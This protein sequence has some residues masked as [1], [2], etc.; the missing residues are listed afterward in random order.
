[1]S[2]FDTAKGQNSIEQML[3]QM[4]R[5]ADAMEEQ[6]NLL[7]EQNAMLRAQ[8]PK[9]DESPNALSADCII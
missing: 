9:V 4:K 3:I 1:M 6:N 5:I 8:Q 2:F 7:R